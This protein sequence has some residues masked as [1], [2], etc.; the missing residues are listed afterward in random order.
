LRLA[1]LLLE[2]GN[3][4]QA[5]EVLEEILADRPEWV[6]ARVQLGL[7]HY[8]AGDSSAART[9]WQACQSQ[10]PDLEGIAAYLAMVERIPG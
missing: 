3:P 7:A 9:I 5:R 8:L 10:R 1:R 4:L 2:A 6:D